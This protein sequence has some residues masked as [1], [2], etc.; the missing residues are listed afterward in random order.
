MEYNVVGLKRGI[1]KNTNKPFS[2]LS[3]VSDYESYEIEAGAEGNRA[4]ELYIANCYAPS[5]IIGKNIEIT[6]GVGYGGKA[7]VT[8][9]TVV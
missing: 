2:V 6:Y 1:S 7:V 9:Y 4:Q 5:E 3:V 8:G